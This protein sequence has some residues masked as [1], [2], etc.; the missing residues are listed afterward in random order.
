MKLL[1]PQGSETDELY[2]GFD[3]ILIGNGMLAHSSL[4]GSG[5]GNL[6]WRPLDAIRL[7]IVDEF[8]EFVEVVHCDFSNFILSLSA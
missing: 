4:G 5:G 8:P 7:Q 2:A 6:F 1:A 3:S